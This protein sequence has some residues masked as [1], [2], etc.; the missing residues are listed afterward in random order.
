[1]AKGTQ[2][3]HQNNDQKYEAKELSQNQHKKA[4]KQK[5][6]EKDETKEID[7]EVLKSNWSS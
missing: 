5:V 1:M 3:T 2:Y 7:P 4:Q 6:Q